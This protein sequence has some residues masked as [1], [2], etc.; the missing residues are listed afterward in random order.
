[1]DQAGVSRSS[2]VVVVRALGAP[3][4]GPNRRCPVR[5]E[6]LA[7][8][9]EQGDE[10]YGVWGGLGSTERRALAGMLWSSNYGPRVAIIW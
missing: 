2:D 6:C 4:S 7:Y 8:A 5:R 3:K 9:L 10:L 1:M